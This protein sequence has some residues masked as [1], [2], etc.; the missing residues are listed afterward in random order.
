M[1]PTAKRSRITVLPNARS[2][3]RNT[4]RAAHLLEGVVERDRSRGTPLHPFLKN[5]FARLDLLDVC[6][7]RCMCIACVSMPM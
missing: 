2:N 4:R 7:T 3:H 1:L 5:S 6:M